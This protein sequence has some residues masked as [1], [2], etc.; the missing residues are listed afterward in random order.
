MGNISQAGV[1]LASLHAESPQL[2]KGSVLSPRGLITIITQRSLGIPPHHSG[3][4]QMDARKNYSWFKACLK[5]EVATAGPQEGTHCLFSERHHD[6]QVFSR[7]DPRGCW[8]I[9]AV[10]QATQAS[11]C[12]DKQAHS[13]SP[14]TKLNKNSQ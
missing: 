11:F 10:R 1:A 13:P 12:Q 5:P 8:L 7:K 2:G 9:K 6:V 4:L 14:A 3:S